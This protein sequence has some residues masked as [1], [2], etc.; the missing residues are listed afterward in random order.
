VPGWEA[1]QV[2]LFR[3]YAERDYEA[4]LAV[5]DEAEERFP[6][7]VHRTSYWR[8]FLLCRLDRPDAALAELRRSLARGTW[9]APSSLRDDPDLAPLRGRGEF[10]EVVAEC[11]RRRDAARAEARPKLLVVRPAV[12]SASESPPLLVA[13]HG[14]TEN[15]ADAARRWRA[16]SLAG[17]LVA[18]PQSG[19]QEGPDAF[20][21]D[22]P[23]RARAE[24][25][26]AVE[27]VRAEH[28]F[29][30]G[31]VVVAGFSQGASIAVCEALSADGVG[32]HGLLAVAPTFGRVGMPP[33]TDLPKPA[34]VPRAILVAG[35][36][37]VRAE[38]ARRLASM[39]ERAGGRVLLDVLPGVGHE[40]PPDW[41]DRL[42]AALSFLLGTDE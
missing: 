27:R 11:E 24:L 4:A 25:A 6:E 20:A 2:R 26:H 17:A 23:V 34:A 13:L 15:A 30:P 7:R 36:Q 19:L 29:H 31:R 5:A 10:D 42:P 18:L 21:W 9:F 22:D 38:D 39:L 12:P 41:D 35:E 28:H 37:D 1:L 8:A 32:V 14:R 16:A 33:L 3:L 40:F